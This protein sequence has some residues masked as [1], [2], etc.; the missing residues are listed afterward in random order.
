MLFST[1]TWYFFSTFKIHIR[2]HCPLE[3]Y[4]YCHSPRPSEIVL[5][6]EKGF[7]LS[8]LVHAFLHSLDTFFLLFRYIFGDTAPWKYI[9]IAIVLGSNIIAGNCNTKNWIRIRSEDPEPTRQ[10]INRFHDLNDLFR[11]VWKKRRIRI[12]SE[13][14]RTVSDPDLTPKK[15]FGSDLNE[16][17]L[18]LY[19]FFFCIN[20]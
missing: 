1:L 15:I 2:G 14:N 16:L 7:F 11:P 6:L 4:L 9:W 3:V 12:H 20:W 18:H 10:K 19:L 5:I 13:R 8:C 17:Q